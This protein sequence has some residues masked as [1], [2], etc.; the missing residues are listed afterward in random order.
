M[1]KELDTKNL[2]VVLY[3]TFKNGIT[4]LF[5]KRLESCVQPEG[6]QVALVPSLPHIVPRHVN[7]RGLV[8][9]IKEVRDAYLYGATTRRVDIG[10]L[11]IPAIRAALFDRIEYLPVVS[12]PAILPISKFMDVANQHA[13]Q[14]TVLFVTQPLTKNSRA[15]EQSIKGFFSELRRNL[16]SLDCRLVLKLHPGESTEDYA[17]IGVDMIA[18]YVPF[19]L[20]DIS[21]SSAI[22]TFSSGAVIGSEK[23]VISC[24]RLL[25]FRDKRNREAI[26]SLFD[27]RLADASL[28]PCSRPHDWE[29]FR[30]GISQLIY[31]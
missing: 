9:K 29:A 7:Q 30:R 18:D 25:E 11:T 14:Q 27:R 6:L 8:E 20:L 23:P 3:T 10:H 26:E 2:N 21:L 12:A 13:D 24:S 1:F 5:V 31:S 19:Q 4:S 16:N 22:L 15:S 17:W 28:P